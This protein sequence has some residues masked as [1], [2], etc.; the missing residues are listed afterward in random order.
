MQEKDKTF[1]LKLFKEIW[2][3]ETGII[4]KKIEK[5][6]VICAPSLCEAIVKAIKQNRDFTF[7]CV[8]Q[9]V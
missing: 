1:K 5:E 9:D 6:V 3:E 8:V 7:K 2:S 4:T